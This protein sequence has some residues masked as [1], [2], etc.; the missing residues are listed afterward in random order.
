ML[1]AIFI[2]KIIIKRFQIIE[3]IR[4]ISW[5][6]KLLPF[7]T[8]LLSCLQFIGC[9]SVRAIFLLYE[10]IYASLL[11]LE[12][13][14]HKSARPDK[15]FE[16]LVF[17]RTSPCKFHQTC[18]FLFSKS[19]RIFYNFILQC[20][21]TFLEKDLSKNMLFFLPELH[22]KISNWVCETRHVVRVYK[23]KRA[24]SSKINNAWLTCDDIFIFSRT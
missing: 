18:F 21:D 16:L 20:P 22:T 12:L 1:W 11:N 13:H 10:N 17:L 24:C 2:Y 5:D 7:R 23:K 3:Q 9:L 15:N 6:F 4:I 14:T 8:V 19:I